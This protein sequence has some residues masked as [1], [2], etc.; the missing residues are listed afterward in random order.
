MKVFT[1]LKIALLAVTFVS[2]KKDKEDIAC[3]INRNSLAGSYLVTGI[4]YKPS[5]ALPE[6]DFLGYMPD[7]SKDNLLRLNN[8]GTY[9]Y[10]EGT[11]VCDPSDAGSGIWTVAGNNLQSDGTLNGTIASYDC[12]ALVYYLEDVL[13]DGDKMTFTISR[14]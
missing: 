7:C 10:L 14:Q 8:D 9:V 5:A 2:C 1:L 11:N 12:K 4:S 6:Q 13:A 3:P